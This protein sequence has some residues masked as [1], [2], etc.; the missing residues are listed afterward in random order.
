MVNSKERL[1]IT[2]SE[3]FIGKNLIGHLTL[4]LDRYEVIE[5]SRSS[6]EA[7]EDL[8]DRADFIFHLAGVNRPKDETEFQADNTELTSRIVNHLR[9]SGSKTPL[10]ITSSAQAELEN[11]YGKS[12]LAAE[13]A[14]LSWQRDTGSPAFIYRL[15]GVFGK[16]SRPNYNSV[17]ATWCYN[18]SHDLPVEI[19]DPN[20]ILKLVYIDDVI[21]SFLR[22]LNNLGEDTDTPY[23]E[24]SPVFEISLGELRN[25]IE[26]LHDIRQQLLIPDLSEKLNK[27]LYATY[28]SYLEQDNFAYSLTKH[29]DNRGWLAE[30]VKSQSFGQVFV[31]KTKP[32]I[33]RGDH[34]HHTKIEKFL[35]VEGTAEI[36]FRNK[37]NEQDIIRY[38]VY[39]DEAKVVDIPTGYVHAIKNVGECDLVTIFWANEIL[40]KDHPDTHYEKV[41]ENL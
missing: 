31:S 6:T 8:V 18:I 32:G 23:Q 39:G 9:E 29:E 4:M 30:F 21:E 34:W 10:L 16:W 5:Y 26:T 17:V 35:V 38:T 15:P 13:E 27:Y 37:I 24:V 2:G 20:H 40:D 14:V 28:I 33:S 36:T 22:H 25:R 3:G 7:L 41:E 1:L 11:P 19:S 12:K